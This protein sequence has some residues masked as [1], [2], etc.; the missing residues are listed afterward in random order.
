MKKTNEQL[1]K[2]LPRRIL[3]M[4]LDCGLIV[5]C[6]YIAILLRFDGEDAFRRH[7]VITAMAPMLSYILPIYM[8]VFWFGGLYEIMWEYAGMRDLARLMCLSGLATG[9]SLLFDMLF[10][11]RTISGTVL[12]IGAVLNT[13]AVAGV[14]FLWRLMRTVRQY[15]H[16]SPKSTRRAR[17][18]TPLLIVGAGNAGAWAVNL[19]KTKNSTFGNPVVIVDD[20]LTK[21]NLRVQGV[22]VRGTIS[23]IPELV[24]KY[25][26]VEIVIAITTLKGERLREVINLC[27]STHCRVR[28]LNDPQAV[29][30]SGKPVVAGLRELNTADFLSRDEIQLNNAQISEYLHD[31][32]VL[33]TGGGGSI[34]SELCRQIM[35]YSPRQLLIFD[36]YENCAYELEMELHNKYGADAP[37]ITLIGSIRDKARLDEVFETYHP[38]VVFHAAAHKHVPLMEVSPAEA[39][40]NNVFGTKNLLTSAAEH[41]VERFVQLSTDKAVNPTNVMGCTKRICEMLIQT[42]ASN[43]TM[44]CMAVRFGNVLGSHGSVIP[45]FEEQIKRGGPVT[46][47][48]PDIVRYFMTITEAAQLVLQAGGLA[49]SGSIYVLDMGE[50]VRI[51]DLANR[52]IRFYGYEPGVDIPIEI[53][54]LRPG[55]KLY[56]EL[57][58]DSEQ[59]KMMS[60]AHNKIFIAPP[61]DIDLARFYEELQNLHACAEHNDEAV[62]V[63]LQRIV[64]RYHPNRKLNED[65]TVSAAHGN[66]AVM[67]KSE[68]EHAMSQAAKESKEGKDVS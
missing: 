16:N 50:P 51:M 28:M 64:G 58:L 18:K 2:G 45:L 3:L 35:R 61:M 44:K 31:K 9:F 52:L 25:H 24:R 29:D 54:G 38:S 42:F 55:E 34:G 32:I 63:G 57:M 27:N 40:K 53:T 1:I 26:I 49:K 11:T 7:E 39:V 4:L 6:Y 67:D 12:I 62:V 15:T 66:T 10:R 48:H 30:E 41:D 56:E 22:P 65:H 17:D 20:D 60:T 36:I 13:A 23:D 14:R 8:V 33:V 19:C 21:K 47:T 46:I 5:L 37:I 43:T 68:I 59:D